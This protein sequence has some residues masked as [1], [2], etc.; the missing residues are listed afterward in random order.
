MRILVSSSGSGG[1]MTKQ[2]IVFFFLF[3]GYETILHNNVTIDTS[4]YAFV[5]IHTVLQHSE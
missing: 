3:L 2:S 1:G 4:H 5:K